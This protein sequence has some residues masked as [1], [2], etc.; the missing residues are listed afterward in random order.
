MKLMLLLVEMEIRQ[1]CMV[2]GEDDG[3]SANSQW[4]RGSGVS[5][6]VEVKWV[7]Q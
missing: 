3:G 2:G 4:H 7:S 6:T 5:C 1:S